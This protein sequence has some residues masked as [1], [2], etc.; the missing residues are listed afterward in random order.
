MNFV[1]YNG[2][3]ELGRYSFFGMEVWNTEGGEGEVDI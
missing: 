3:V 2:C 1:D